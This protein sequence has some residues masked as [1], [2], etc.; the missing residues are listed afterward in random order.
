MIDECG[1]CTLYVTTYLVRVQKAFKGIMLVALSFHVIQSSKMTL[2]GQTIIFTT[3]WRH[4]RHMIS[5]KAGKRKGKTWYS[6]TCTKILNFFCSRSYYGV[7]TYF[8]CARK[9]LSIVSNETGIVIKLR[10]HWLDICFCSQRL[11]GWCT[12]SFCDGRD[13]K[14]QCSA[15]TDNICIDSVRVRISKLKVNG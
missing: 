1:L 3:V 13:W 7:L 15:W 2:Q 14:P 12:Q 9:N 6:P 10:A 11:F 4:C 5:V 8:K